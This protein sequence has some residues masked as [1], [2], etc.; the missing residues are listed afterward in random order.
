VARGK[1]DGPILGLTAALHGN[2]LNGIRVIQQLF[3]ELD[4]ERLT[5]TLVG[6]LVANVPGFLMEQRKF[7]DGFDLNHI[8]PGAENG[9][10]SEVYA[11]RLMN[12]V[13]SHFDYLVDLHTASAGRINSH[14]IRVDMSDTVAATMAKLQHADIIV[15][16]PPKDGTL[17][18]AAQDLG[19][20]SITLELGDPLRFQKGMIRSGMESIDNL[21]IHFGMR[22]GEIDLPEEP[23]VLCNGSY[24]VYT[25]VGGIL[26]VLPEITDWVRKGD[27]I[28]I[29]RNIFGDLIQEYVASDD[30][31]VIGRSTNPI[32]QTGARILHLGVPA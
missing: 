4:P 5:G 6:V 24:W 20:H 10:T 16:N 23:P 2:E 25:D 7:N 17:R 31:I 29:V 26:M 3:S 14:Y 19:I 9:N 32:N 15:D 28:A 13:I 22:E 27:R 8:M 11:Y 30:G 12:R 21:L 18:G 1:E